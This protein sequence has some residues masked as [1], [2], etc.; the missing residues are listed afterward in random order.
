[1]SV[2]EDYIKRENPKN[3]D[4]LQKGSRKQQEVHGVLKSNSIME[5][6]DNYDPI[7]VGTIPIEIDIESSDLDILCCYNDKEDFIKD[8][9][10]LFSSK[11]EFC[12]DDLRG[13][14]CVVC[15]FMLDRYPVEIYA[16]ETPV[17]QQ[18]GYMHM[19]IEYMI[20]KERGEGF[21][22]EI[23]ELKKSG[24][25]TEPA[26]CR[27]LGIEGDPYEELIKYGENLFD[28]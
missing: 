7:L 10:L 13:D 12:V 24:Y 19:L 28:I 23:I 3:I 15:R 8:M 11:E 2:Q 1:M 22:S 27:L 6:L 21:R 4:Y 26:F 16:S 14:N 25:K 5:L 20:L 9:E 17:L 18:R